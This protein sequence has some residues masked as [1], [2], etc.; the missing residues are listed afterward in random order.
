MSDIERRT[1]TFSLDYAAAPESTAIVSIKPSYKLFIGGTFVAAKSGKSFA[2]INPATE[3]PL[4]EVAEAGPADV[5]YRFDVGAAT[6]RQPAHR[7]GDDA[8]AWVV[9]R[10]FD[11]HVQV[12]FPEWASFAITRERVTLVGSTDWGWLEM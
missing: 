5:E 4:A 8:D 10:W 2:T 9:E 6:Q 12:E 3:E 7:R 1:P 11:D